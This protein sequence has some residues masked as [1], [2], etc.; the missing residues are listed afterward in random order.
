MSL[1]RA[2]QGGTP[3]GLLWGGSAGVPSQGGVPPA[4]PHA[5]RTAHL[6]LLSHPHLQAGKF[7]HVTAY[8]LEFG[9]GQSRVAWLC[10]CDKMG[11]AAQEMMRGFEDTSEWDSSMLDELP[12]CLHS[13]TVERLVTEKRLG[14]SAMPCHASSCSQAAAAMPWQS[15]GSCFGASGCEWVSDPPSLFADPP[16]LCASMC[17]R[18]RGPTCCVHQHRAAVPT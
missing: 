16:S 17:L 15:A 7:V 12:R 14:Q 4:L 2:H 18:R 5:R 11:A 10:D 9:G 6:C 8:N 1:W 3:V 13:R